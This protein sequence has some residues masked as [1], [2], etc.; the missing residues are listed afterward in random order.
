[1]GVTVL[2]TTMAALFSVVQA[3]AYPV[4][5]QSNVSYGPFS[6]NKMDVCLPTGTTG[7]RRAVMVV[8][9]GGYWSGDKSDEINLCKS[10]AAKGFVAATINYR[11]LPR[12]TLA[13][14]PKPLADAQL[15]V[16]FLR[17]KA[18]AY[19]LDPTK[20]C[21]YG[22]SAGG[23]LVS[24]TSIKS[25]PEGDQSGLPDFSSTLDCAVMVSGTPTQDRLHNMT[26]DDSAYAPLIANASTARTYI[27]A[28]TN[29]TNTPY[30]ESV[31]YFDTL[32][33]LG[34][35]TQF[36]SYVGGHHWRGASASPRAAIEA[37]IVTWMQ[38]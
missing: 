19:N 18:T 6:L 37:A 13:G 23:H 5:V 21:G 29:D 3:N 32:T 31:K 25:I 1:M 12:D 28:G 14:W 10:L 17:S 8:H 15:A 22:F 2:A 24:M 38:Q 26:G 33:A 34:V 20:L 16:R 4:V 11:F 30:A 35:P 27:V 36:S 7:I 9:G